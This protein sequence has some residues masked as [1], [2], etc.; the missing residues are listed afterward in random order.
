VPRERSIPAHEVREFMGECRAERQVVV[1][2][3]CHSGAF[4]EG[5]KAGSAPPAITAETFSSGDGGGV[6]ILTAADTLQFAWDGGELRFGDTGTQLS[7]FTSWLV[8][9][10]QTGEAA[11]DD[12][13]IT[14][15]ALYQYLTRRA[16]SE[17][18]PSTPQ[19]FV[20][21]GA[22]D[23][24]ISANPLASSSRIDPGT[25]ADLKASEY[26]RRLGAVS[27]L[28]FLMA[29]S[30]VVVARAACLLLQRHLPDERDFQVRQAISTALTEREPNR[31]ETASRTRSSTPEAV[32]RADERSKKEETKRPGDEPSRQAQAPG[33]RDR[34]E[35]NTVGENQR[36]EAPP[37]VFI[38]YSHDSAAHEDRVL[39]LANRLRGDGVDATIDQY[40]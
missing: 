1:L 15:D 11:P 2:D 7:R 14:M 35:P 34:L 37:R 6:Y 24:V 10:L 4:A 39:A 16:R 25:V 27:A 30:D 23:L 13:R 20:Q 18:A 17:G 21:G 5:G 9:G 29:E 19:R 12:E 26:R 3:C 38:S 32:R 22:G 28:T 40:V 36:A 31:V 8:D 33:V